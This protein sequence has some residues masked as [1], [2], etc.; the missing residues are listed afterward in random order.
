MLAI[1]LD[2]Q[3]LQGVTSVINYRGLPRFDQFNRE[4]AGYKPEARILKNVPIQVR[5]GAQWQC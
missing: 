1:V 2:I 3:P 4:R 5:I